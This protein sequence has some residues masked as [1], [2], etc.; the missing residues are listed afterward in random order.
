[1]D[2]LLESEQSSIIDMR[3]Q[4]PVNLDRA[5]IIEIDDPFLMLCLIDRFV[6]S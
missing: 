5:P 4:L 3:A 1:M 2:K 6:P